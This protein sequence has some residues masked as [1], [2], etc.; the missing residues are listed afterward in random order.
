MWKRRL[1][2]LSKMP[3]THADIMQIQV[4]LVTLTSS[5]ATKNEA[6]H[7]T[8]G[9][10]ML[11][12]SSALGVKRA[13]LRFMNLHLGSVWSCKPFNLTPVSYY[14]KSRYQNL[15]SQVLSDLYTLSLQTQVEFLDSRHS[16]LKVAA[17][18]M[19]RKTPKPCQGVKRTFNTFT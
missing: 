17:V 13:E 3:S 4:F 12:S 6:Q 2:D 9:I 16:K 8:S 11:G 19:L 18:L 7:N 15:H 10:V 1:S 5:A 14:G